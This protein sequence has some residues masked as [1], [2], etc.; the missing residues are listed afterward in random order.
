M[1]IIRFLLLFTIFPCWAQLTG[2]VRNAAS[3]PVPFATVALIALADSGIV[4]GTSADAA[5][6][7]VFRDPPVGTF[8]LRITSVGY[9][10]LVWAPVTLIAHQPMNLPDL[11]LEESAESLDAVVVTGQVEQAEQTATGMVIHVQQSLLTKGSTA[12]QVLE[13]LPGVITDRRNGQFSLNGQSGVTVLINGRKVQL[14]MAEVMTLLENTVADNV[15][16]VELIT[17][18]DAQY[19][20]DGGAGMINIVMKKP[21]E[22]A[23]KVN[24]SATGGY[25]FR[26]KATTS[27]GVSQAFRRISLYSAY[28]FLYDVGRSGYHGHGTN[29]NPNIGGENYNVFYGFTEGHQHTHNLNLAADIKL[30]PRVLLGS[31]F[32]LTL[33]NSKNEVQMGSSWDLVDGPYV[34]MRALSA[35]HNTGYNLMASGYGQFGLTDYASLNLDVSYVGHRS[36]NPSTIRSRYYDEAGNETTPENELFTEGNRGQNHSRIDAE[37]IKLDYEITREVLSL[38]FGVKGSYAAN[39]NDSRVERMEDSGWEV[40]PRSQHQIN[41]H[42]VIGAAY[43]QT[44][45][46]WSEKHR[47]QVGLRYEYWQREID[48][49]NGNTFRVAQFFPSL[50][51]TFTLK[52]HNRMTISY[53]RR[54]SRPAYTDLVSNVFYADPT[55]ILSGNPYL[56]PAISDVIK[57]DFLIRGVS[58]GVSAQRE[59]H[60]ILRYQITTDAAQDIG[61]SS[62]QN[63]DYLRSINC[64][65]TF[66]AQLL[67]WWRLSVSSTTALRNY[68]IS[69]SMEPVEDTFVYQSFNFSQ[70]IRLPWAMEMELSGWYNFPFDEGTNSVDGFGVVNFGLAKTLDNDWGTIQLA[71]PDLLRTF[72]VRSHLGAVAPLPFQIHNVSQWQAE[73]ALYQVVKLTY[74]RTFGGKVQHTSRSTEE[75]E[76]M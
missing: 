72:S 60:P 12:L 56:K 42:E 22:A 37:V 5:G 15:E 34:D 67:P 30:S 50:S 28:S 8:G 31:D 41:S 40:D 11:V 65:W 32:S 19:D 58:I 76:R 55:F 1:K 6:G 18:P 61:I 16:Q 73:S 29:D 74:S 36:D 17:A 47:L 69:Y 39:I 23:T 71:M 24:L 9:Q 57:M 43:S 52:D 7:F 49:Q 70:T 35:G 26:E 4:I 53:L 64:Y 33:M 59:I 45:I 38:G 2:H 21:E 46:Q 27:L 51:Q 20:A 44:G 68:R 13:R 66:P 10:P 54:I 3:E 63:L 14:S 48:G 75:R 62:P 25:G